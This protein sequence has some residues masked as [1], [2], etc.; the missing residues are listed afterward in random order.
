MLLALCAA[1]GD[2]DATPSGD[3]GA[4]DVPRACGPFPELDG[5]S[6]SEGGRLAVPRTGALAEPSLAFAAVTGGLEVVA[7]DARLLVYAGYGATEGTLRVT[8]AQVTRNVPSVA[9]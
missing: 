1:C 3:G 9:P 4:A 5:A 6:V 2:A 8:C 7:D